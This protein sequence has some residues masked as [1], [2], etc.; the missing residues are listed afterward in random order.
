MLKRAP[1]A[2]KPVNR[3]TNRTTKGKIVLFGVS[4]PVDFIRL[5]RK[6][7]VPNS[8][9]IPSISITRDIDR[10]GTRGIM[11]PNWA[12]ITMSRGMTNPQN[13]IR[14]AIPV[15]R[16]FKIFLCPRR[17]LISPAQSPERASSCPVRHEDQRLARHTDII[18]MAMPMSKRSKAV[19]N[20]LSP[21]PFGFPRE[22][23]YVKSKS[24]PQQHHNEKLVDSSSGK[25]G[26]LLL[27]ISLR[28]NISP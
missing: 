7:K 10:A 3:I 6:Y 23:S 19:N 13:K 26:R 24:A 14:W 4:G 1:S 8:V 18:M 11:T 22:F 16:F 2:R 28:M 5:A 27:K 21:Q 15:Y 20:G 12:R 9:A 17:Y 25:D